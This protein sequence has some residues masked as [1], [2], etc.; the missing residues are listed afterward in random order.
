MNTSFKFALKI[1]ILTAVVLWSVNAFQASA[2]ETPKG[3]RGTQQ[4]I[5]DA[6]KKVETMRTELKN[7]IRIRQEEAKK[8]IEAVRE[9]VKQRIISQREAF[10]EKI[11]QMKD[12]RK[13]QTAVRLEEQINQINEHWTTHFSNVLNQL[14]NVLAKI[15]VRAQK[16]EAN[17]NDVSGVKTAIEAAHN[18]IKTARDAVVAQA[19]KGYTVTFESEDRLKEAFKTV[20]EQLRKDLTGLRDGT[21]KNARKAVQDVFQ[22]LRQI[23]G[24]D[25]EPT[26]T[27]TPAGT[28]E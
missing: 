22:A 16:A 23:P 28:N 26:A 17:G 2:Q 13:R 6:R 11:S 27:S 4:N 9:Q 15:E 21:I 14:E 12:E 3:T 19:A 5:Q 8:Q 10:K 1:L 7:E 25:K 18:V 20:K 24:V